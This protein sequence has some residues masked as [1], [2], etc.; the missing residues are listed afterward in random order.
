MEKEIKPISPNEIVENLD[1]I[2]PSAIIKAVNQL[3]TEKYRGNGEISIKQKD[4]IERAILIDSALTSSIIWEK[5]Y[6]DFEDLY[7]K[8]GWI[9]YY[10]KPGYNE[11]YEAFFTFKKK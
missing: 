6:L 10:D 2:I 3:L 8:N 9:V 5:H 1:K 4:I 7:R 11:S